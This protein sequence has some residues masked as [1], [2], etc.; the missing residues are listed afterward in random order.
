MALVVP[1][2]VT[3]YSG[4]WQNSGVN[5]GPYAPKYGRSAEE[6]RAGVMIGRRGFRKYKAQLRALVGAAPGGTATDSYKRVQAVQAMNDAQY[7]GGRR[8]IQTVVNDSTTT[9]AMVTA[10]QQRMIDW[11]SNAQSYPRDASGNGGGGKVGR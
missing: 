11:T 4:F 9:A 6:Y 8:T 3:G 10:V 5:T 1:T 7:N 2:G